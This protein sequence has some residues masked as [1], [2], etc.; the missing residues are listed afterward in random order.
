MNCRDIEPLLAE[1]LGGE[2]DDAQGRALQDHLDACPDCRREVEELRRAA[3]MLR[4][5]DTVDA[6]QATR[7]A[8]GLHVVRRRSPAVR[9]VYAGLR[10]AAFVGLGAWLGWTW[11]AGKP[12]TKQAHDPGPFVLS[13]IDPNVGA[14]HPS[15]KDRAMATRPS[16]SSFARN[17]ALVAQGRDR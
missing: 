6:P 3:G 10:A 15:W 5:L 7:A 14:V 13:H 12:V 9:L 11:A 17:L 2:L 8:A 16:Q 4:A 1:L